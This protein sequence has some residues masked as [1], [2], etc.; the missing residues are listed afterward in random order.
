MPAFR[1][2]TIKRKLIALI[3]LTSSV[4]LLVAFA[5]M[6]VSDY[7]SFRSGMVRDLRTL[8]DVMGTSASSALDFDD[9]EFATKTLAGLIATPNITTAAIYTEDG[10]VLASYLRDKQSEPPPDKPGPDG[11]GFKNAYFTFFRPGYLNLFHPIRRGGE[12]IGSIYLQY[13]LQEMN[14]RLTRYAGLAGAIV[15]G[16]A[17]IAFL[18]S[19]RLQRI[20][21]GPILSL[22]HTAKIVS[23]QKNYSV[24][25]EKRTDDEIG[26]LIDRFNEMLGQI[27]EHEKEI[28]EVNE[29]LVQ[30]EQRARA[31]T[32]AKSH[33]LANMS[34]ELR[35]PLN[36][37]IGYSEMLQEEAQDSGQ[38]SFIPDLKKINRSGRHLLDLINDVLDLSKIEAGKM[39]LYLET[40]DI[41]NLL[42]DVSTTVQL[43][44]QKNSNVL[45]VRCPANLGAMRADMTK[46]R[47]SLFNLLSNASKFTKNGKITLEAAR[48]NSPTKSDWIV[49][50]VSDTGI[51]MTPEQQEHVFE[52]FSQADASTARDFGGTGLGLTITK[53]FCRMMGGDV[54][55]TSKPG[56]GT[57]FIIRLPTEVREP[58]AESAAATRSIAVPPDMEGKS[59]LVID[60]DADTRQVLK[61]FLN[62]KGFSVECASNGEEG[63][64]LAKELHPMA[65]ILDV[66]MPGMDGWAVLST[67]KSKPD[68]SDIPVVMLTIVDDKNLGYT[69]GASD[70]MIKP[71]DRERLTEILAK[72]RDISSPRS[73]LVVDD[74]EADRKMLTQ[75]L[76]R[77]RWSVIQ[78]E[79]GVV[80][81]EQVAKHRPDLILLDLMM[82]R[83]NGYQFVTELHK[84]DDW[85]S[86][87]I[88]VVTAKD[89]STE[90]RIALDGY[91]EKVLPKH[92]LTQDSLL[93]EIQ[94][95]IAACVHAKQAVQNK[96]LV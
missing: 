67:L 10:K 78:A 85:R 31:A 91:V 39:E 9:E 13:S 3:M 68:L 28:Q 26:F 43:L 12:R 77:E 63:L 19:S 35:T 70:Y 38:E 88:I 16:A 36:A 48:E 58:E 2:T 29:Q 61:R 71:V 7:V 40:F 84:H 6:I 52:A 73:A 79:D 50:R 92:A 51:G 15:L 33:F 37:I 81:L 80:A 75:I 94:D 57:T 20:I 59:V 4:A 22:A 27:E 56:E 1:Q 5:L 64:R 90:E 41:S 14:A 82:P 8:A 86:I 18:F 76:E 72:F 34:H 42:E 11:Y 96:P 95:L 93:G 69:L 62:R 45:E 83:M 47:Q 25:A 74:E 53:T 44:V 17:L 60:D 65:I 54:A 89:M 32:Q 49:F 23:E 21:S 55:L 46:V 30:S 66:M 24:R 87:P